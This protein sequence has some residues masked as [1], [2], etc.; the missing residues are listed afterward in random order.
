[1]SSTAV[2]N[3]V[4]FMGYNF[5][6]EQLILEMENF[7]LGQDETLSRDSSDFSKHCFRHVM[8]RLDHVA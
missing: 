1:M 4:K 8:Q 5:P 3:I 2:E 6:L 7:V